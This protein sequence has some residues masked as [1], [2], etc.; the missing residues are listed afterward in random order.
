VLEA[1][2]VLDNSADNGGLVFGYRDKDNYWVL[3]AST[4]SRNFKL[5]N[6]TS[7]GWL[8]EAS[9]GSVSATGGTFN[10]R[11]EMR[12]GSVTGIYDGSTNIIADTVG[13][14]QPLHRAAEVTVLAR[15]KD[16]MEVV[17]HQAVR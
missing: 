9:G 13:G 14:Q 16:E 7:G 1:T 5:Y 6:V 8:L 4:V 17:A 11:L 2:V 12:S 10:L 3:L 15:P